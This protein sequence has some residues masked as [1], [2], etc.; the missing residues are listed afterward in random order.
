MIDS[1]HFLQSRLKSIFLAFTSTPYKESMLFSCSINT[2]EAFPEERVKSR[3]FMRTHFVTIIVYSNWMR[4]GSARQIFLQYSR[5]DRSEE[6]LP[7]RETVKID[8]FDH[9]S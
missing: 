5:M 9:S 2:N 7:I 1:Y 3:F 6:N 4:T 8:I